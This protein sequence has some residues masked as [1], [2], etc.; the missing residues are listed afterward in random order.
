[1][2]PAVKPAVI[3]L[4]RHGQTAHNASGRLMGH[5]DIGLDE[6]G[7]LQAETA[8]RLVTSRDIRAVY[9]SDLQ[10]ARHTAERAAARLGL[11]VTPRPALREVDVGRWEGLT[12]AEIRSTDPE[13]YAA[14]GAD[15][16]GARR[17]GGESY[18]EMADRVWRE[19]KSIA[20]AH[21]GEEVL[22]VSHGG[23]MRAVICRVL[24][25]AWERRH[26]LTFQ[27]CGLLALIHDRGM[28][29][30]EVPGWAVAPT[31]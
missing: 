4:L 16:Y 18:A 10:R 2:Q 27:N 15:P 11:D 13:A 26:L 31:T 23:P 22:A 7:L 20:A 14:V 29:R 1:M 9:C 6:V 21:A 5:R 25:L 28:Y 3:Y 30:L 12:D 19:L 8:A 17:P 24:G